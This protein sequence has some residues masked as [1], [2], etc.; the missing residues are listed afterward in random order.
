MIVLQCLAAQLIGIYALFLWLN[1][2][3][4]LFEQRLARIGC[5]LIFGFWAFV[6]FVNL[7][8]LLPFMFAR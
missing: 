7:A 1:S 3:T 6:A 5:T 8:T 4:N 2:K